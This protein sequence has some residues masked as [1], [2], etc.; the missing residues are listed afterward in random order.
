[1]HTLFLDETNLSPNEGA[2]FIYGGLVL[3]PEQMITAHDAIDNIRHKYGYLP[4]DSFKFQ[5]NARPHQ[6]SIEQC[7]AAKRE[8][9]QAA[10]DVGA[11]LIIYV[12]LHNIAKSQTTETNIEWAL[13]SMLAHFDM[14][15]LAEYQSHGAVCLDRLPDQFAYGY[16]ASKFQHGVELPD[17]RQET[18]SRIIHYSVSSDG[19]S[20]ISS[21]VDIAL[22]GMRYCVNAAG[23]IGKEDVARDIL[24]PLAEM[25]WHKLQNDGVRQVGSYGFLQYPKVIKVQSYQAEYDSLVRTLTEWGSTSD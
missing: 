19:A 5:T 12:V 25:M 10:R 7:R 2:F 14:R 6:L 15:F 11:Q 17:G 23:G 13:N 9:I 4:G 3:T 8:A 20:H 1:M 24:P 18:L 16:L 21:L 22:G